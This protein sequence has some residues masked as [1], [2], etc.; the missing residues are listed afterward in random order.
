MN[1]NL[2]TKP[3]RKPKSKRLIWPWVLLV[4]LT[5]AAVLTLAGIYIYRELTSTA[6]DLARTWRDLV[7]LFWL[8]MPDRQP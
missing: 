8:I 7:Q 5:L 6:E 1:P 3:E 2:D 4:V